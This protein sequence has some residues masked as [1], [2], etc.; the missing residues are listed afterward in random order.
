MKEKILKGDYKITEDE[1][2]EI[3][4]RIDNKIEKDRL[5]K[6]REKEE[7]L[8]PVIAFKT[9][10]NNYS[11]ILGMAFGYHKSYSRLTDRVPHLK[12]YITDLSCDSI[13]DSLCVVKFEELPLEETKNLLVS[14]KQFGIFHIVLGASL[15]T[16]FVLSNAFSEFFPHEDDLVSLLRV[17]PYPSCNLTCGIEKETLSHT[18]TELVH[19]G[20][21]MIPLAREVED[22]VLTRTLCAAQY[23]KGSKEDLEKIFSTTLK[24]TDVTYIVV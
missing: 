24:G 22:G 1:L 21:G 2:P 16:V 4:N 20:L 8:A 15:P 10:K 5:E 17:P 9:A 23:E 13:V 14:I 6:R 19:A 18:E 12:I 7:A 11:F 3:I